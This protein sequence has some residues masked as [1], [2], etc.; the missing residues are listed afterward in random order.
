MRFP[1]ALK[2]FFLSLVTGLGGGYVAFRVAV[3]I[4]LRVIEGE[5]REL[6]AHLIGLLAGWLFGI[7]AAITAGVMAGRATKG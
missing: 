5:Q 1:L 7:C 3:F 6:L 4:A 2:I